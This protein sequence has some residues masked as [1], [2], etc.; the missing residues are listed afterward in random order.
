ME[1]RGNIIASNL[2]VSKQIDEHFF[3][4]PTN[5][6]RKNMQTEV[7]VRKPD[8]LLKTGAVVSTVIMLYQASKFIKVPSLFKK[9]EGEDD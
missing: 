6:K 1:I 9:K 4:K 2:T 8:R 3:C 5:K 7:P